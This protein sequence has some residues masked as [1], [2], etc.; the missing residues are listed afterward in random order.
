MDNLT[1]LGIVGTRDQILATMRLQA[2]VRALQ[3]RQRESEKELVV[4]NLDT[5]DRLSLSDANTAVRDA[6]VPPRRWWLGK[7]KVKGKSVD[8]LTTEE[9]EDLAILLE[10]EAAVSEDAKRNFE[11]ER[12]LSRAQQEAQQ[13]DLAERQKAERQAKYLERRE[14]GLEKRVAYMNQKARTQ[15]KEASS[16]TSAAKDALA[17]ATAVYV[18]AME[19]AEVA[20]SEASAAQ[21]AAAAALRVVADAAS[22]TNTASDKD[23]AYARIMEAVNA[24]DTSAGAA[25]AIAHMQTAVADWAGNDDEQFSDE[26]G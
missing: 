6:A 13:L 21:A 19:A 12:K 20:N 10:A 15:Q 16:K 9:L 2:A 18:A 14:I 3:Q 7:R 26:S 4:R 5:G 8:A 1:E 23:A 25:N 17:V 22:S 24:L 11:E